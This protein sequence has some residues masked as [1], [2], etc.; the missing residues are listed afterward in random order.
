MKRVLL[1]NR[2]IVRH[3]IPYMFI[4]GCLMWII[5]GVAIL[6]NSPAKIDIS[7]NP[8][9]GYLS[10]YGGWV[11]IVAFLVDKVFVPLGVF[12]PHKKHKTLQDR[13][14]LAEQNQ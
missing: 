14:G 7:G 9:L 4:L 2:Q 8:W 12:K 3:A 10:F 13:I 6:A 11:L 1:I 5:V